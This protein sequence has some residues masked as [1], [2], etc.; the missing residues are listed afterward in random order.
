MNS[1]QAGR[2]S[3]P[4]PNVRI[5]GNLLKRRVTSVFP[6][7]YGQLLLM[8]AGVAALN[9][10]FG[11]S[12]SESLRTFALSLTGFWLGTLMLGWLVR[13]RSANQ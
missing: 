2:R 8:A 4:L 3:E 10:V 5:L 1:E 11:H 12:L 9:L 7:T 6:E 13:F